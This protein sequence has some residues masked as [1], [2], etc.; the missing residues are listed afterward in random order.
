[1]TEQ[2]AAL[3]DGADL[4]AFRGYFNDLAVIR[5]L[6]LSCVS[7]SPGRAVAEMVVDD[8]HRNPDG[9]VNGGYL[10]AIAD[11]TAGAAVV[12]S[13]PPVSRSATTDLTMHFLAPAVGSPLTVT[14]DVVRR[15]RSTCVPTVR[16]TDAR[17]VLCA[18]AT[19]TWALRAAPQVEV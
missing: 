2:L 8:R 7:L 1:M 5:G 18:I 19:G 15:G 6:S 4:E 12:T 3:R 17:G 11:V 9:P 14:A 13:D 16:I 10:L